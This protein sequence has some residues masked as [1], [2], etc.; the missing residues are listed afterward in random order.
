MQTELSVQQVQDE[1]RRRAAARGGLEVT[2]TINQ[3][4]AVENLS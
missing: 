4:A 1:Q 3:G 2:D